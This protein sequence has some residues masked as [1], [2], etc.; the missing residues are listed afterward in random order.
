MK[1]P[2]QRFRYRTTKTWMRKPI[3]WMRH[4]GLDINDV[5]LAEYP[6][7]GSTWLRFMLVEIMTR[8]AAGFLNVSK[9]IPELGMHGNVPSV[10]PGGGRLIKT[11]EIWRPDYRR[12]VYLV[13]DLRDTLFSMYACDEGFGWL[14]YFSNGQGM[15]GYLETFLKGETSRFGSWQDN[16]TSFLDSP[17]AESGDMLVI[18]YEDMRKDTEGT[19][20][21]ILNFLGFP[22]DLGIIRQAIENNTLERMRVKEDAAKQNPDQI[23]KGTLLRNHGKKNFVG[24]A[25]LGGWR[26][27]LDPEQILLIDQYAGDVLQ[28]LGYPLGRDV[29]DAKKREPSLQAR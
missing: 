12:V 14:D 27:R 16:V 23:K 26:E 24:S 4:C 5:Y 3:V 2:W 19:L 13:R 8:D 28:R 15:E 22:V 18:R 25:P 20:V 11:H 17:P 6:R 10:L 1:S 9:T 7:G 21:Q 29:L